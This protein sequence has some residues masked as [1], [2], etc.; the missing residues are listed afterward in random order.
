MTKEFKCIR[1]FSINKYDEDECLIENENFVIPVNSI[2]ES[3]NYTSMSD[4]RLE[5]DE[6]GWLEISEKT[7]KAYFIPIS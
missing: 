6:V 3:Q 4:V 2:W 7:F 1:Q 5:N